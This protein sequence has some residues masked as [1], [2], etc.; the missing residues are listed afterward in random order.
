MAAMSQ[1]YKV[2]DRVMVTERTV[3]RS[4]NRTDRD[5]VWLGLFLQVRAVQDQWLWVGQGKP[6]WLDRKHVVPA[7]DALNFLRRQHEKLPDDEQV[8]YALA[9]LRF[10]RKE[11][12]LA[13]TLATKLINS[14]PRTTGY[15]E[16]RGQ[17]WYAQGDFAQAIKDF[18][19]AIQLDPN[20]ASA[21][22]SRG[23]FWKAAGKVDRALEDYS[24]AIELDPNNAVGYSN[25]GVSR[26][27]KGDY[28]RAIEDLNRA[29]ELDPLFP[30]AYSNRGVAWIR[31][32]EYDRAIKDLNR[33]I[34]LD[35]KNADAYNT[36]AWIRA[37][38]SDPAYRNG[39]QAVQ[40]A[41][42][43]LEIT[44]Q[45]SY[46][47]DTLAA[48]YAESGEFTSAIKWQEKAIPSLDDN[49]PDR[50]DFRERLAL[51]KKGQPYREV[52]KGAN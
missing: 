12:D 32:G 18:N 10:E 41:L 15:H 48:A 3:L 26:N 21:Y 28:D 50:R 34:E 31:K 49:D 9:I 29:V 23:N 37:T 13:L 51:Y 40:D 52:T 20:S 35:P 46:Y 43:A 17:L 22:S 36:R 39:Q 16:F 8:T 4:R 2:G 19:R 5:E 1:E 45:D 24:R 27:S 11:Y 44:N 7:E 6:G 14:D 38:C 47:F 25:R 33:A 42:K 30:L